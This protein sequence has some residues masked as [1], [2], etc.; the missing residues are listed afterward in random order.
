MAFTYTKNAIDS[1]GRGVQTGAYTS[2]GG[3]VGGSI[4]TDFKNILFMNASS[5]TAV[6][7]V[8]MTASGGTITL[9]TTA[10]QTGTWIAYGS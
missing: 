3:S 7:S 8:V 5:A 1:M 6:P 10:N 9:T 4:V 2:D